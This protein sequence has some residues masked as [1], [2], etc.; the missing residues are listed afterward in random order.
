VVRAALENPPQPAP[1]PTLPTLPVAHFEDFEGWGLER[2]RELGLDA[3]GAALAGR[4]PLVEGL[5][6]QV[7]LLSEARYTLP[8]PPEP[9]LLALEISITLGLGQRCFAAAEAL[10]DLRQDLAQGAQIPTR[11]MSWLL[12]APMRAVGDAMLARAL[13]EARA[14]LGE[15]ARR[16]LLYAD[17]RLLLPLAWDVF[18]TGSFREARCLRYQSQEQLQRLAFVEAIIALAWAEGA[19]APEAHA[20][21]RALI[22]QERFSPEERRLL[23]R[24][25]DSAPPTPEEIAEGLTD[26]ASRR[27]LWEHLRHP[28]PASPQA[29]ALLR[30]L[31]DAF[32]LAPPPP[33]GVETPGTSPT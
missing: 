14:P 5:A 12:R 18:T 1:L 24:A 21:I 32:G 4:R 8:E 20:L 22:Q 27:A 31:A 25:L 13:P 11:R 29:E 3:P 9:R 6:R 19:V 28:A 2:M 17:T 30:A 7:Q 16:L 26:P 10:R 15:L 23:W 33:P